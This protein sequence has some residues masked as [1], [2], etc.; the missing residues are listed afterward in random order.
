[1]SEAPSWLTSEN[2]GGAAAPPPEA[3]MAGA[4]EP[5]AAPEPSARALQDE[6]DLPQVILFM[7]LANMG[8]AIALVACS[9]VKMMSFPSISNWILA[10][11]ATLFGLLI[12]CLETQLKFLRVVIAVNFGFLFSA[13]WRFFFYLLLASITWAYNNLFGKI[14]AIAIAATA[15]FNTYVLFRYPGYRKLREKI[16]EEEDKRIEAKISREVK[17]QA[18]SQIM[19]K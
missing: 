18:V 10:V 3:P 7:R 4:P 1:M 16:A 13:P 17:K 2:G 15:L 5:A 8:I 11:Y 14:V 19:K 9:I 6:K 12:C